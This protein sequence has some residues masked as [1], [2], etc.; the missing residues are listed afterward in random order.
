LK[1]KIAG[2]SPADSRGRLSPHFD[3]GQLYIL[4]EKQR[5]HD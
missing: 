4:T 5:G 3:F 1:V 2:R